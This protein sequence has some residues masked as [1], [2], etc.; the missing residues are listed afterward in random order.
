MV[1]VTHQHESATGIHVYPILNSL[2]TPLPTLSLC[3]V[4]EDW[5]GC[6]ASCIKL[7]LAIYFTI[8]HSEVSQKEKDKYHMLMHIYGI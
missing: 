8:A 7:A 6:P 1:F 5:L 2:L 4:P 3:V